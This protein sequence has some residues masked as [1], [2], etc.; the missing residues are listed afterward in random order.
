VRYGRQKV[1]VCY[2]ISWWVLVCTCPP[3]L[4]SIQYGSNVRYSAR[5]SSLWVDVAVNCRRIQSRTS[6]SMPTWCN[7]VGRTDGAWPSY[8]AACGKDVRDHGVWKYNGL[9]RHSYWVHTASPALSRFSLFGIEDEDPRA[10]C[11]IRSSQWRC[12]VDVDLLQIADWC[13]QVWCSCH[14][15][16]FWASTSNILSLAEDVL[17]PTAPA[18]HA[19]GADFFHFAACWLVGNTTEWANRCKFGFHQQKRQVSHN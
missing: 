12:S 2:L 6:S 4:W 5:P 15:I 11:N 9:C 18:S 14:W 17:T 1:H 3:S 16:D 7:T 13:R 19:C 8:S 10:H